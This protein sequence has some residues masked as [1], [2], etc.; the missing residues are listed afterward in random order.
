MK[1]ASSSSTKYSANIQIVESESGS[2]SI[3]AVLSMYN[4]EL[5]VGSVA[6][7]SF[8]KKKGITAVAPRILFEN[9]VQKSHAP[10][11]ANVL[12]DL[13]MQLV[14]NNDEDEIRVVL[15]GEQYSSEVRSMVLS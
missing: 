15:D 9:S 13:P 5:S 14:R 10:S 6:A 12:R 4:G 7:S 2:R 1:L 3:P 8:G 11:S